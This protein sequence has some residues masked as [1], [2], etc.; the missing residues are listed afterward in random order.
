ML[1]DS[2]YKINIYLLLHVFLLMTNTFKQTVIP[3][4]C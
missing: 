1:V 2:S 3:I 4:L